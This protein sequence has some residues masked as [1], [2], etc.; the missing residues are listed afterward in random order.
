MSGENICG[1]HVNNK[2][3]YTVLAIPDLQLPFEHRDAIEFLKWAKKKYSPDLIVNIGDEVDMH[4]LS[5]YDS[6]PDGYSAGHELEKSIEKLQEYYELFPKTMVCTS[7]HTA[8]PFR[9]AFASGIPKAFIRDYRE[10]LQ[11][12]KG[13]EWRDSWTVDGVRYEHGE[14]QSGAMGALKAAQSNGCS[15]V[16]GHLHS[17]AGIQYWANDEKILYGFNIGCLID[18]H[19]YAFAYGKILKNKPILGVGIIT[20]GVPTFVPLLLDKHG[21]WVGRKK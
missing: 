19:A 2:G 1:V 18:R 17:H 4:A 6:D 9:K 5:N 14:G 13:W 3:R 11:A 10:F 21:R 16:I 12:P 7:N 15:T 8:R 20:K